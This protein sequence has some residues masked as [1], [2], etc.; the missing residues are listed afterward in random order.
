MWSQVED[1]IADVRP[2]ILSVGM[3]VQ[4]YDVLDQV[5]TLQLQRVDQ[6]ASP[7]LARLRDFVIRELKSEVSLIEDVIFLDV[8]QPPAPPAWIVSTPQAD[9]ETVVINFQGDVAPE[10]T[11][12]FETAAEAAEWPAVVAVLAIPGV[13]TVM[14]RGKMLV[15]A[16]AD[17][18]VWDDIIASLDGALGPEAVRPQAT[19]DLA[20]RVQRVLD[21]KIN[22]GV[23]AHGGSIVLVQMRGTE[24]VVRMT[25]GCQGCAQSA[26]TLRLGVE[27]ALLRGVPEV[28][29]VIDV[30][31]HASGENPFF[32]Q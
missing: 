15:V 13:E 4:V 12:L 11:S 30:T 14:G 26:A 3:D 6:T 5:V 27:Q 21:E 19:G 16:K 24:A 28:T 9:S 23:A 7:D 25:G 8:E 31:D 22:P 32:E 18:A 17:Y 10:A 29:A 2:L 1:A 20:E